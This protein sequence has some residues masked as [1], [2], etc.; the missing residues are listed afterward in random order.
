[1]KSPSLLEYYQSLQD[2]LELQLL[3]SLRA[4]LCEQGG[5]LPESVRPLADGRVLDVACGRGQWV[6]AMAR[7][8]PAME[9]LGRDAAQEAIRSARLGAMRLDHARFVV[10][11]LHALTDCADHGFD[12][13]RACFIAPFV[14]PQSWLALLKELVRVCRPGGTILWVE[15]AFPETNSQACSHCGELLR[16]AIQYSGKTPD[17]T[18]L[19]DLLLR[20]ASCQPVH[21]LETILNISPDTDIHTRFCRHISTA[22]ALIQPFLTN[23]QVGSSREID[24]A[25]REAIMDIY[26]DDFLAS[27]AIHTV[28][29]ELLS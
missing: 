17:I 10:G 19:M 25:C 16:Q 11:D 29:A 5:L 24:S 3:H 21:K 28:V 18:P 1:M 7:H 12:L 15:W 26:Q 8:Y 13:V 22:L 4:F 14:A 2:S 9:L 27:W 6:Q 20:D 23:K